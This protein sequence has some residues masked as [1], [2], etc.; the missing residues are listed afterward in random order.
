[1][2]ITE[3]KATMFPGFFTAKLFPNASDV[4][5]ADWKEVTAAQRA[6][7]EDKAEA[8]VRPPQDFIN[9]WNEACGKWGRFNEETGYFEL[10]GLTDITY[11]EAVRIYQFGWIDT[12][13][14]SGK[15]TGTNITGGE[16]DRS[17]FV[18]TNIPRHIPS[19]IGSSNTFNF[20]SAVTNAGIEV[21]NLRYYLSDPD[22]DPL[23]DRFLISRW[24]DSNTP[25]N[26]D[27]NDYPFYLASCREIIGVIDISYLPATNNAIG[28][29]YMP[30]MR[31]VWLYGIKSSIPFFA[32]L[33]IGP[34][35]IQAEC[36][37]F[38]IEHSANTAPIILRVN[39]YYYNKIIDETNEEW[40]SLV[41]LAA[42]KNITFGNGYFDL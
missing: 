9:R 8:W 27:F 42:A 19:V 22:S 39:G 14:I 32:A 34:G 24:G 18:R 30:N 15:Y 7:L 20:F 13:D 3:N 41:A 12:Y 5:L 16:P 11:E 25:G 31:K 33:N 29:P 23:D 10:N 2:Y 17:S 26:I 28:F 36:F 21:L 40:H 4:N 6:Q 37:R 1:M 35:D 38:A